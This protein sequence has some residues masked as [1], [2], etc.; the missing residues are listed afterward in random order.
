MKSNKNFLEFEKDFSLPIVGYEAELVLKSDVPIFKKAYNVP[1]RLKDKVI[2]YLDKLERQNVIT[3]IKISEW[4]SPVVIVMKKNNDI[5]LVIDCK[6]SI[7]KVIIPNT[8]PLPTA[9]DLFA[10]LA[11]CKIFCALDL[12]G[13]Y[14]QLML[15]ERSRKF[16]VINTI[17]GL[18]VYNRLPQGASSSASIFQQIMD[19]VLEGIDFVYCY[20]DDVLIAGKNFEE[21]KERLLIVLERLSQANIKVNWDKCRFFVTEL[22]YL[23]HIISDR[24]LLPCPDKTLTI[25]K[26][27]APKNETELKS[28]LGLINY[29]NKFIPRLSIKLYH[30]YNLLKNKV[31][32]IWDV[33][34]E[35]AFKE[36][37]NSLVN[38]KFLEFY[39]PKKPLVVVSDASSYGLGGVISHIIDGA[40]K[41]ISFTSFSLNSAQRKYPILHLEALALVSTVKKFH[42]Y[43]YGQKFQVFTDHKPLVGIFG[44]EGRNSIYVTRLQR[45]V[46]ELSIYEFDIQYRPSSRMGNADFC[47]RFPL[48][49]LVPENLDT[50]GVNNLNFGKELPIDYKTIAKW[51]KQDEFLQQ[52]VSYLQNGWPERLER[53]YVDIFAN[54]HDL[55][56]I[57]DCLLYQDRVVI[58]QIM[59]NKVLDLLHANHA[60]IVKMKQLARRYVYWFGINSDIDKF[61]PSCDICS[62]MTILPKPKLLSK[63]IPTT[64]PFSILIFFFLF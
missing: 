58:P 26:A 8:Y 55:E 47:S 1:Y 3:P 39:D 37:K 4:A 5:R 54:H 19:Q 18:Y 22:E 51:S 44:K 49:Q 62:S 24:G 35:E 64:K 46:L 32:F 12:E 13:A 59:Q 63:W 11:G 9:Q 25:Q 40:E 60:G 20:L 33:Q 15:T 34:C 52:I 41:P 61:V 17:K 42:K 38:A 50:E 57:E 53:R 27:K 7:N 48:D 36:S 45:F 43:L 14:T 10:G 23:G 6:V 28:Y 30:L 16:M 29:Y 2:E 31:K 21:C 56:I